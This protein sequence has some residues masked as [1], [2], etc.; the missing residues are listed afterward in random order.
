V[1]FTDAGRTVVQ[2]NTGDSDG[3]VRS[4][5]LAS[6]RQRSATP[7][8][9]VLG[10]VVDPA[11]ER[12][13][14]VENQGLLTPVRLFGRQGDAWRAIGEMP[15]GVFR[16]YCF[17]AAFVSPRHALLCD[18]DGAVVLWDP[19]TDEH[20]R[21]PQDGALRVRNVDYRRWRVATATADA[22]TIWVGGAPGYLHRFDR[23][24]DGS[25]REAPPMRFGDSVQSLCLL[26]DGSL[27]IGGGNGTLERL[28]PDGR[29]TS[30]RRHRTRVS[31]IASTMRDGALLLASGDDEG[32]VCFWNAD[33]QI[34]RW[35]EGDHGTVYGIQFSP[36][37]AWLL[38]GTGDGAARVLPARTEDLL[39]LARRRSRS[40]DSGR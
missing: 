14:V 39:Q 11:G 38:V 32:L 15:D 8:R 1:A 36:D 20:L 40:F 24:A 29:R 26:P 27:T 19:T 7:G 23:G 30:F 3:A 6:G 18:T 31:S 35:L 10:L 22:T 34:E 21:L 17:A 25:Y 16:G 28:S 4:W 9:R 2:A 5:D 12:A 37:G 33:G 13:V